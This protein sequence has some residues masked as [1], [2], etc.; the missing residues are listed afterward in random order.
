M[1]K[2]YYL[3]VEFNIKFSKLNMLHIIMMTTYLKPEA[4]TLNL[5]I[6]N[7]KNNFEQDR[8]KCQVD[9]KKMSNIIYLMD[10]VNPFSSVDKKIFQSTLV[11]NNSGSEHW[12]GFIYRRFWRIK[13]RNSFFLD[14]FRFALVHSTFSVIMDI[15]YLQFYMLFLNLLSLHQINPYHEKIPLDIKFQIDLLLLHVSQK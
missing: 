11:E 8:I 4:T 2:L 1:N 6:G 14:I 5:W 7:S 9:D 15:F 3:D 10:G 12:G 13:N